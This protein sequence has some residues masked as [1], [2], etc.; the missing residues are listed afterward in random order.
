MPIASI[1]LILKQRLLQQQ[2]NGK[3]QDIYLARLR[4]L[5]KL[6]QIKT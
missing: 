3:Q 4:Y 6:K 5:M 2:I 1:T